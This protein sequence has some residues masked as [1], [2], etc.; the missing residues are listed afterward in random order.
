MC[1]TF[2]IW[3]TTLKTT[4]QR[5]PRGSNEKTLAE[6]ADRIKSFSVCYSWKSHL[7]RGQESDIKYNTELTGNLLYLIISTG[8]PSR[9]Y[10]SQGYCLS[11]NILYSFMKYIMI[12]ENNH[13]LRCVGMF[14]VSWFLWRCVFS[15]NSTS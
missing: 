5:G 14:L 15:T 1:L 8:F 9:L 10:L 11:P 3:G 7:W 6:E 12:I 4:N 2:N 13:I